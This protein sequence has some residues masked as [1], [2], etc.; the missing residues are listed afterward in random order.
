[1]SIPGAHGSAVAVL[2]AGIVGVACALELQRRGLRV[3]LVD[4]K[5]PASETS[6]GNAGI[7]SRGSLVPFNQPALVGALPGLLRNRSA[8]FRYAPAHLVRQLPWAARFLW[9]ARPS[10]CRATAVALDALIRLSMAEH[11]RLLAEAG[12]TGHL[13]DTGWLYAYRHAATHARSASTRR[14]FD[15]F[16]IAHETVDAAGIRELEPALRP[17]FVTGL[18]IRDC[19]SVDSP[20]RVVQAYARLFTQRGGRIERRD[21][22]GIRRQGDQWLVETSDAS[23]AEPAIRAQRIVV[24]LGPWSRPFLERLGLSVPMAWERGYHMH[25]AAARGTERRAGRDA[26]ALLRRPVYDVDSAC[27]L[28]PME[29][30]IRMTTG[31]DLN[32]IDAPKSLVQIELAEAAAR[33]ALP[34]GER[35][36][37]QPWM[38][39][40]P[41]LPDSRPA[42]G[43]APR[44]PD[45]WLAFGHQHIGFSTG[46]GTARL[47]AAQMLGDTPAIDARPFDPRRCIH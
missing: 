5:P 19:F 4:R 47:L 10:S 36:D 20:G 26:E 45:V 40:R 41:T 27:I 46:P 8:S 3:T 24:A 12:E 43:P 30:G 42:I 37:A 38:G 17:I 31:V 11:R 29:R 6:Y 21:V 23:V 28:S 32:A 35:L 22:S 9:N 33:Q 7:V 16:G 44:L 39:R 2:G 13:R 25:F 34:L 14:V 15:A 1:M 18:W